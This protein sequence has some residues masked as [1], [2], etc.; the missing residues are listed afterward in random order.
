MHT[1]NQGS[2]SCPRIVRQDSHEKK[3]TPLG[4]RGRKGGAGT[5]EKKRKVIVRPRS[6]FPVS[7]DYFKE[8]EPKGKRLHEDQLTDRAGKT[9]KGG[10]TG[11]RKN[12][13]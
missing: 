13:I 11:R 6:S 2:R 3:Q 5:I 10:R 1:I 9:Q 4:E 7:E 8:T 12:Q